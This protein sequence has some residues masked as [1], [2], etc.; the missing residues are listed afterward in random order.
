M[1]FLQCPGETEAKHELLRKTDRQNLNAQNDVR[2][3]FKNSVHKPHLKNGKRHLKRQYGNP[4][5]YQKLRT[6]LTPTT[7]IEDLM[8]EW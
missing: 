3:F 5:L 1:C 6:T 2:R 4:A 7:T 8:T